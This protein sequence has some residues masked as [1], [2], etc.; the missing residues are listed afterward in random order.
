LWLLHQLKELLQSGRLLPPLKD[1]IEGDTPKPT[2]KYQKG[3]GSVPTE[4]DVE[5]EHSVTLIKLSS[6]VNYILI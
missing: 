6:R 1:L 3:D 5:W 4:L 2:C